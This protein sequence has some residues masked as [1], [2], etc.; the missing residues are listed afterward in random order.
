MVHSNELTSTEDQ[1]R[2]VEMLDRRMRPQL[3][4]RPKPV[5]GLKKKKASIQGSGSTLLRFSTV[6]MP[7]W[8]NC[9]CVAALTRGSWRNLFFRGSICTTKQQA[10]SVR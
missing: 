6:P 7:S 3:T 8:Q 5:F 4:G 2:R 1:P 9:P 10:A